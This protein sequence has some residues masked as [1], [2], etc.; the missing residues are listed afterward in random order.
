MV[1]EVAEIKDAH[2]IVGISC[3]VGTIIM[4]FYLQKS[5]IDFIIIFLLIV[6][7]G[8]L[9]GYLFW[10]SFQNLYYQWGYMVLAIIIFMITLVRIKSNCK[11]N[12]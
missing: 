4:G 3:S 7:I 8:L 2:E 11:N 6:S 5:S 10:G 9:L 1:L 12:T